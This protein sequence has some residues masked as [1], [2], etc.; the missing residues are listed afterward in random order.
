MVGNLRQFDFGSD[1]KEDHIHLFTLFCDDGVVLNLGIEYDNFAFKN[2]DRLEIV[3]SSVFENRVGSENY[4]AR[5]YPL[6]NYRLT[7]DVNLPAEK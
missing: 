3:Y 2:G 1:K 7:K 6:K 5:W 4:K